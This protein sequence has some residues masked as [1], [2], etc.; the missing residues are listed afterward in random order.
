MSKRKPSSSSTAALPP[1]QS[2]FSNSDDLVAARG[3]R[4]GGGQAAEPAA[5][6][7]DRA[8]SRSRC[9]R[10]MRG[11][12]SRRCHRRIAASQSRSRPRSS[13]S[14]RAGDAR[15]FEDHRQA[16]A[17]MRAAADEIDAVEILEAV[18]RA[19]VQ[20]LVERVR[21]VERRAAMDRHVVSQSV[22]RQHLL[23][24]GCAARCRAA[25]SLQPLERDARGSAPA[26]PPSRCRPHSVADRHQHVQRR[27][28]RRR[29][30]RVGDAGVLHVER[31]LGRRRRGRPRSPRCCAGSPRDR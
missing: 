28:A 3:E 26:P 4:A 18:A 14:S 11:R 2:F 6:D 24:H 17:R 9:L 29:R 16:A 21:Q 15:A 20:H 8:R 12:I 1:S 13:A 27:M 30:G 22:G 5:D 23:E 10:T 25:R 7:A 19:E 31:R